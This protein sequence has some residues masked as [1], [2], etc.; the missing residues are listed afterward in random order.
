[1]LED[2][3]ENNSNL[4]ILDPKIFVFHNAIKNPDAL[5]DF[6]EEYGDWRGWYGFGRQIDAR[7]ARF[8]NHPN[9]PTWE[10]WEEILQKYE[11]ASGPDQYR[12]EIARSFYLATKFYKEQTNTNLP[13]WSS[14]AW[15]LARYVPDEDL[16]DNEELTMNYHTDY[17]PEEAESPG[18][19]FA[20]TAVVYPNDDYDGG[21]IAFKI[22]KE[23]GNKVEIQYKP[24]AGD[25]VVFPSNHPYYHGVK[26][27]YGSPKY[28][29][30]LY[31]LY[32]FE[33]TQDWHDLKAK[34]GDKFEELE[35]QRRRRSDLFVMNPY[36]KYRFKLKEYYSLLESN[37]LLDF[38]DPKL[39]V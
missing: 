25:M 8:Q 10:D 6:Y 24:K 17:R 30:R 1:M 21:E 11:D 2:Y 14:M 12:D 39:D 7:G 27:V 9:F 37:Q 13:N 23:D 3:S 16:I 33:G 31:W 29:I 34:Y 26:R 4:T 18:D 19:K 20:I 38:Y 5:I 22:L 32:Y 28:I 36:M 15:G 35:A